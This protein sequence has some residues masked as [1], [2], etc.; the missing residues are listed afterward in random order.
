[1]RL[2]HCLLLGAC[3]ALAFSCK[4]KPDEPE[5]I[6]PKI[7]LAAQTQTV[8]DQGVRFEA[9][10]S[11]TP[12]KVVLRFTANKPWSISLA[13]SKSVSWIAVEPESG[14]AGEAVVE[15][16][17][18]PNPST[19]PRSATL[20]LSC[21]DLRR[22]L[23]L[24][25]EG[26]EETPQ[27]QPVAVEKV[28]LAPVK[29]DLLVGESAGIT[30]VVEPEDADIESVVWSSSDESVA[31]VAE[32]KV[33][34]IA[35]GSAVVTLKVNEVEARC[36]VTV[37]TPFVAVESIS[38]SSEE[39][40]LAPGAEAALTAT[41]LPENATE[42]AVTWTSSDEA[43]ATVEDGLVKALEEGTAVITA[44]AGEKEASCTVTVEKDF[45]PVASVELT[46]ALAELLPGEQV[47]LSVTVLPED[48][49]DPSVI[50]E[51]SDE[52]VA[53][54]KDGLVTAHAPGSAVITA[55]AGEQ[56]ARCSILVETPYVAVTS[57]TL[58]P[59]E[60][61]LVEG[62]ESSVTATVLPEDATD[63]HV[64]FTSSDTKVATV[65]GGG[66]VVAVAPGQAVITATAGE[67]KAECR[68]TV[69]ARFIPVTSITLSKSALTLEVGQSADLTARVLPADATD[70]SV[71]WSSSDPAVA[72]VTD[73]HVE[74]L[75]AG[76]AVITAKAGDKEA[77]C[78]VT[79]NQPYVPVESITL[80]QSELDLSVGETYAL[81]ATVLPDNAT[82][83][84]VSWKSN[85]N[86]I[87]S[88]DN[89]GNVTALRAGSAV[90]TATAGK[91]EAK[92][93]VTVT[94]AAESISLNYSS[95]TLIADE[96]VR[97]F[98]SAAPKGAT[99]DPV[100]WTSSDESVAKVDENGLVTA[101]KAG[102]TVIT[103]TSG[104]LAP[105]T[106][107]IEVLSL[108]ISTDSFS[109]RAS[110][111][112]QSLKVSGGQWTAASDASWCTVSPSSGSGNTDVTITVTENKAD[113]S[114]SATVTF[115][116]AENS[117]TC[118]VAVFQ[119]ATHPR[120]SGIDWDRPFHHKSLFMRF[121]GT[122][123]GYC[124]IMAKSLNLALEQHPGKLEAVNIHGG[125]NYD[126][127]GYSALATQFKVTGVPTGFVDGRRVVNNGDPTPTAQLIGKYMAETESN[128]PVSSA[129]GFTS[130]LSGRT[131]KLDVNLFIKEAG[132]YKVTVLL[133]ENGLVGYQADY[134]DGDHSDYHH[135]LVARMTVT[136]NATGD[137]FQAD[138]DYVR[139]DLSYSVSIPASYQLENMTVL[140]Y[141][142]RAFGQLPQ[143]T[144]GNY[145]GYFVDNAVSGKLGDTVVPAVD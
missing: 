12:D 53:T 144:S 31:T 6:A 117:A 16:T 34:G 85:R 66:K 102:T 10:E 49:T 140:V 47:Q 22:Q 106:C 59:T 50:W 145:G 126:Y 120:P 9:G 25:Q 113:V 72:S 83:P 39:L 48:A 125:G 11:G 129:I 136:S 114:R 71:S 2:H 95:Y 45:V 74:A 124:P 18:Q 100:N 27:P 115:R 26:K 19:E 82:E 21:G 88:V 15:V 36:Q 54:V 111:G 109:F 75:A 68:V 60:I 132:D 56:E 142:Q 123:C 23:T 112:S 128:Y 62:E 119:D 110:G 86:T 37:E 96:T 46:P 139:K 97:L 131:L 81:K 1:M 51:S 30:Y 84:E 43:V 127:S 116:S 65:D 57:I 7:E 107:S 32:G 93:T 91:K 92:C 87:V 118:T 52:Q 73:G 80:D 98:V 13:E 61:S 77:R 35:A 64:T 137:A 28:T 42:P 130:S 94:V 135:D 5:E 79:V 104:N 89:Q 69:E 76:N 55:R 138:D 63:P 67:C 44:K 8:F 122:W 38:L 134:I 78:E 103:A 24:T 99:Y 4:E 33:T 90:I 105:A 121:T 41:V 20:T 141:V 17:A 70:P 40:K 133:L 101:V 14:P 143:L 29:M 58:S 3:I 108:R